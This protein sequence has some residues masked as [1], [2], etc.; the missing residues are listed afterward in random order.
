M[1]SLRSV[2]KNARVVGERQLGVVD[3]SQGFG[4]DDEGVLLPPS[5]TPYEV[6]GGEVW[7]RRVHHI[8]HREIDHGLQIYELRITPREI[9]S[10]LILLKA[11]TSSYVVCDELASCIDVLTSPWGGT[12]G[13]SSCLFMRPRIQGSQDRYRFLTSTA[14]CPD[15]TRRL[16]VSTMISISFSVGNRPVTYLLRTTFLFCTTAFSSTYSSC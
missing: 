15:G 16:I 12:V 2:T 13:P 8:A 6:A 9:S 7:V 4:L 5:H 1:Q 10:H 14:V 3:L 11:P